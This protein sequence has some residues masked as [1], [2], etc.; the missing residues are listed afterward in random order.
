M[1]DRNIRDISSSRLL[2][3]RLKKAKDKLL[4]VRLIDALLK[5]GASDGVK[6]I[7]KYQND[8]VNMVRLKVIQAVKELSPIEHEELF[9][10]KLKDGNEEI[11]KEAIRALVKSKSRKGIKHINKLL[12]TDGSPA[13]KYEAG[14][15][16]VKLLGFT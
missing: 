6:T 2:E 8:P 11:R 9:I 1:E 13:D 7:L 4:I 3:Q 15:A 16:L 14:R 10:K 12:Y 5:A